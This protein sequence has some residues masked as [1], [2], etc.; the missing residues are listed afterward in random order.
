MEEK[1]LEREDWFV[2]E[3]KRPALERA[4]KLARNY[5]LVEKAE[6]IRLSRKLID[7]PSGRHAVV[8]D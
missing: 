7:R 6:L 2:L 5:G 4:W 1:Y 3:A 8:K